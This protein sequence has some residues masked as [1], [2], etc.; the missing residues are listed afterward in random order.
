MTVIGKAGRVGAPPANMA[1]S[2]QRA[3]VVRGA[4]TAAGVAAGRIDTSWTGEGRQQVATTD[5]MAEAR[6]GAVDVTVVKQPL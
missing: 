1:L 3:D 4:L 5:D 6:D 2:M